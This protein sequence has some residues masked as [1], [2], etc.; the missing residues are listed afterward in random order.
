M[1]YCTRIS[2]ILNHNEYVFDPLGNVIVPHLKKCVLKYSPDLTNNISTNFNFHN[3]PVV[4]VYNLSNIKFALT[5]DGLVKY[6]IGNNQWTSIL[7]SSKDIAAGV[8][9]GDTVIFFN[10]D[11]FKPCLQISLDRSISWGTSLLPFDIGP[12]R[13][14][15]MVLFNGELHIMTDDFIYTS[16]D[17]GITWKTLPTLNNISESGCIENANKVGMI[18]SINSD[19]WSVTESGYTFKFLK[20]SNTWEYKT[21]QWSPG[22]NSENRILNLD[23][24]YVLIISEK[25]SISS[26]GTNFK[27]PKN[28]GKPAASIGSIVSDN[29]IWYASFNEFGIY[30]TAD[31]GDHWFPLDLHPFININ[32]GLICHDHNLIA[33]SAYSGL[34]KRSL[35]AKVI[36]GKVFR[37]FNN[38]GLFDIED[39][40]LPNIK[41]KTSLGGHF[42]STNSSGEYA[43]PVNLDSDTLKL[44]FS[45]ELAQLN[46]SYYIISNNNDTLD[47]ALNFKEN[48]LDG[49][50]TITNINQFRPGFNTLISANVQNSG[51]AEI[52]FELKILLDPKLDFISATPTGYIINNDTILWTTPT[53]QYA[54]TF[55][56]TI[57]VKTPVNVPLGDQIRCIGF[58]TPE[59][60]DIQINDNIDS[61]VVIVVGSYDPNDKSCNAG[62]IFHPD[63]AA[64]GADLEYTIR[65]QNTGTFY[66]ENVHIKD[67][68]DQ[69]LDPATFKILSHSHEMYWRISDKGQLDFY[70]DGINLPDSNQNEVLSHGFV[71]F[72]IKAKSDFKLK[73]QIKNTA[74]IYFDFNEA[75]VT[76]TV[77]TTIDYPASTHPGP[78]NRKTIIVYPNPTSSAISMKLEGI[79]DD[80]AQVKIIDVNGKV[81]KSEKIKIPNNLIELDGLLPGMYFG[82]VTN[83][84]G[85]SLGNFKFVFK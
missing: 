71:K 80:Q 82:L 66:A 16:K 7:P 37:D 57:E 32:G 28:I 52:P 23:G 36:K 85:N 48:I 76:N 47:F 73:D 3:K 58:L 51:S 67:V 2:K 10:N 70:F 53:L 19:L 40:A 60:N 1:E 62:E 14:S 75:I 41:I 6:D 20:S 44:L 38:N 31:Q 43:I 34:W 9:S 22:V 45:T 42:A 27:T 30:Y 4:D 25:L 35:T 83:N 68:L 59:L 81:I 11:F 8:A 65:F 64:S 54:E 5:E 13:K 56:T 55:E 74:F 49:S 15:S 77:I 72:A 26:N 46:P 84:K 24:F 78:H 50:F 17:L 12:I 21:C 29:N 79:I 63:L 69:K 18:S 39:V 33:G 61:L